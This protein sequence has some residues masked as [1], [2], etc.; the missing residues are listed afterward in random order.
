MASPARALHTTQ[1][2]IEYI[3]KK[4]MGMTGVQLG[5]KQRS[6]VESRLKKR[7]GD[8]GFSE[9]DDYNTYFQDH[10][11]Q[12]LQ[13]LV[14]LLTT[15]YTYFF[16]EFA[17]FEFISDTAL[18]Q[19]IPEV[20]ARPDKTL[21]IWS[22]ACSRG[23]EV[24]SL[25]MYLKHHLATLAPDLKFSILGTDVDPQSVKIA[26]NGVYPR[27]EIREAPLVYLGDHWARGTGEISEYVK[28]KNTL[29]DQVRFEPANLLDLSG[30]L[31]GQQFDIIMCRNVFIYFTPEQ[32]KI[33]TQ[34]MMN[35]LQPNGFLF[36]GISES[37]NGLGL[38]LE[39]RGPS[40]YSHT[41]VKKATVAPAATTTARPAVTTTPAP[42]IPIT[43]PVSMPAVLKVLCVD[44]SPSIHTLM[45]QI[46]KKEEG[47]EIVGNAMNGVEA[48]KLLKELP[49]VDL[50]TL[51]IHMP[52]LNGIEYLE[53]HFGSKHPPV[54]MITSVSR[55]NADLA[56][57]SLRLGASDFI[58]KPALNNLQERGDEIRAKLKTAFKAK[59]KGAINTSLDQQ[60][61][62]SIA[63][64][65]PEQKARVVFASL[66]D[67]KKVVSYIR[68]LNGTQPPLYVFVEGAEETLTLFADQL[69]L[70]SGK[71]VQYAT[72]LKTAAKPNEIIL[73]DFKKHF[74]GVRGFHRSH[75]TSI[76]VHGEVAKHTAQKILS[77]TGAHLLLEDLGNQKGADKLHASAKDIFPATSFGYVS[78]EYLGQGD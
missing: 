9:F 10:E 37:L 20:R 49:Q 27:R 21:K 26:Q 8:L 16:R 5:E 57:R 25:A 6:M 73:L 67:S 13:Q 30:K 42:V 56:L 31:P 63:I 3:S 55:D 64:Q 11:E 44:D 53:K 50:M 12:E 60:F 52:E 19:L 77:W 65:K 70:Q 48:A 38:S 29:R 4:V 14:S 75:K 58:E 47:F 61:K 32:I 72:E 68:D 23:Q 7:A 33:S 78:S 59:A 76:C 1:D 28:A 24:Y 34:Q 40:I 39:T 43:P 17:H 22:A 45:K 54:V 36:I 41:K 69:K 18:A 66:S 51:D 71:P 15:H 46:L 62:R 74:D 35:H 2:L